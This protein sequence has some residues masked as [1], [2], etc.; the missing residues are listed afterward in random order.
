MEVI[1]NP[2]PWGSHFPILAACVARTR[3]PVLELGCGWYSTLLLHLLCSS[4]RRLVSVETNMGCF[5]QFVDLRTEHHEFRFVEN[6]DNFPLDQTEWDVAFVDHA[7][8]ERRVIDIGRLKGH[9]RFI[10]VHDTDAAC[11][12]YERIFPSFRYRFDYKRA[13]PWTTVVS[14]IEPFIP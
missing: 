2:D 12:G 5:D 10:V 6:W 3:G 9:A 4:Y 8:G 14:D 11:Y 7:P 13:V 1:G